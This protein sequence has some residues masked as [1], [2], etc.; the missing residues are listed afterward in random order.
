M[1]LTRHDTAGRT[2]LPPS[3]NKTHPMDMHHQDT[4]IP[5]HRRRSLVVSA[6]SSIR[7]CHV[8][9]HQPL[10]VAAVTRHHPSSNKDQH[11]RHQHQHQHQH[12][13]R[14]HQQRPTNTDTN[15]QHQH[16][17]QHQHP[18]LTPGRSVVDGSARCMYVL[19][20]VVYARA[21]VTCTV[22]N[23]ARYTASRIFF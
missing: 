5:P 22:Y 4:I 11:R 10:P 23:S 17:H 3:H 12:Q 14:R 21:C 16:Q 13:H 9:R 8:V 7:R 18:N 19:C 20:D 6:P 15:N 1:H 2:F